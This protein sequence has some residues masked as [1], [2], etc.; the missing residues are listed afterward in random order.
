M[1]NEPP[2]HSPKTPKISFQKNIRNELSVIYCLS[3][4]HCLAAERQGFRCLMNYL[5]VRP[6]HR[7]FPFPKTYL[8][9]FSWLMSLCKHS[10]SFQN[11]SFLVA[12]ELLENSPKPL[13]FPF[14][15]FNKN[16]MSKLS[17]DNHGSALNY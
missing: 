12:N 16:V 7:K 9:C 4:S 13:K 5:K 2:P 1:A 14:Q 3:E 17:V 15:N 11:Q 10:L 6:S 8:I